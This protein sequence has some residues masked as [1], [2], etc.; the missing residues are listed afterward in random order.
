MK[1]IFRQHD[2][3]GRSERIS[4]RAEVDAG[5][6]KD[7]LSTEKITTS[8]PFRI[9]NSKFKIQKA[10]SLITALLVLVVLSTIVV[11]FMQSMSIERSVAR[12]LKNTYIAE[13]AANAGLEQFVSELGVATNFHHA[14]GTELISGTNR[15]S[16]LLVKQPGST[17]VVSTNRLYSAGVGGGGCTGRCAGG[18]CVDAAV[19]MC[20]L[21]VFVC[22]RY[23]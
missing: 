3:I 7:V 10:S 16:V 9:Q 5:P 4:G 18:G 23:N 13:I 12:S 19:A 11:A 20:Y 2:R 1:Q 6:H 8:A 22:N 17:N 14:I 21:I 15:G